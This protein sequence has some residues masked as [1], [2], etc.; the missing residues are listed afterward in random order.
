MAHR[1]KRMAG[2]QA[3]L[4]RVVTALVFLTLALV[5]IMQSV[6]HGPAAILAEADHAAYHA[7]QGDLW[8]MDD[9]THHDAI[10]HDHSTSVI[11]PAADDPAPPLGQNVRSL[12]HVSLAGIAGNGLRR[13][14]RGLV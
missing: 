10:D 4:R 2:F 9:H 14:P 13:P 1:Q 7:E 3:N 6:T 5:P 11:L 12:R 8:Q